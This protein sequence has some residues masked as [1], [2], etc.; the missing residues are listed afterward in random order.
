MA[1]GASER[2]DRDKR[3]SKRRNKCAREVSGCTQ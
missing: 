3:L 2:A 1:M